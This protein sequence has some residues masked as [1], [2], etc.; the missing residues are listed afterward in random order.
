MKIFRKTFY[1]WKTSERQAIQQITS[2]RIAANGTL[3]E[4]QLVCSSRDWNQ[5]P[6]KYNFTMVPVC[7]LCVSVYVHT[8]VCAHVFYCR[9]Q[10]I[11]T[12]AG[13]LY[14]LLSLIS[15]PFNI[16]S[17]PIGDFHCRLHGRCCYL[18][19]QQWHRSCV[20]IH[21][22]AKFYQSFVRFKVLKVAVLKLEVVGCDTVLLGEWFLM[23]RNISTLKRWN[24]SPIEKE[25]QP[26]RLQT[27]LLKIVG[28]TIK[29]N[30][31]NGNRRHSKL[32]EQRFFWE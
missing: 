20:E 24:Y 25:W 19:D 4:G 12:L 14:F 32:T 16:D 29:N 3:Q 6:L 11:I 18:A 23:F 2:G 28:I 30:A 27:S 9:L 10:P 1:S 26:R 15:F 13:M 7:L 31:R 17:V 22:Y 8:H 5:E 21:I